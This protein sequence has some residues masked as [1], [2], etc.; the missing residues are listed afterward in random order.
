M[1]NRFHVALVVIVT[2]AL[3]IVNASAYA[4]TAALFYTQATP[5]SDTLRKETCFGFTKLSE[6][7]RGGDIACYT[8]HGEPVY[9]SIDVYLKLTAGAW[10]V[11]I[12][13]LYY[14]AHIKSV[15]EVVVEKPAKTMSATLTI[16]G[17]AYVAQLNLTTA[18]RAFLELTPGTVYSLTLIIR[19]PQEVTEIIRVGFYLKTT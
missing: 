7:A 3:A 9:E 13:E 4:Y 16:G 5:I 2:L 8:E 18:G 10:R 19:A 15:A 17:E 6:F 1:S 14:R 12:G 11:D